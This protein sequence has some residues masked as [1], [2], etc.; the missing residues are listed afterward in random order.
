MFC[1]HFNLD[2]WSTALHEQGSRSTSL[3]LANP[4]NYRRTTVPWHAACPWLH[5]EDCR[6][7][8]FLSP[9]SVISCCREVWLRANHGSGSCLVTL[10]WTTL[11]PQ[12]AAQEAKEWQFQNDW[13]NSTGHVLRCTSLHP[14]VEN[15]MDSQ[16]LSWKTLAVTLLSSHI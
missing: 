7:S 6:L 9:G 15:L 5:T 1:H 14:G 3:T 16:W 11:T 10:H 13:N 12:L 2:L 8:L 4:P